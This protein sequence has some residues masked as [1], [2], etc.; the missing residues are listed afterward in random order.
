LYKKSHR[1]KAILSLIQKPGALQQIM[2][3]QSVYQHTTICDR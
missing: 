3:R 1:I 2:L